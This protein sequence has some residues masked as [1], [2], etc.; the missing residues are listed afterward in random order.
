MLTACLSLPDNLSLLLLLQMFVTIICGEWVFPDQ[1]R[2]WGGW[3]LPASGTYPRG[4]IY[5]SPLCAPAA[6][7]PL[8]I[9][10]LWRTLG[11][12]NMYDDDPTNNSN[13]G[14]TIWT[15]ITAGGAALRVWGWV[16]A[17]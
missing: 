7:L 10:P 8:V 5:R 9:N 3:L 16:R 2:G 11:P 17:C 4:Q 13:H 1:Q 6:M 15:V 12:G 14:N